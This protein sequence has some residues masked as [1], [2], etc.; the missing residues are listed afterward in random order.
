MARRIE[1]FG[2][3]QQH[4]ENLYHKK[5]HEINS[6][7]KMMNAK[8][9]D[10]DNVDERVKSRYTREEYKQFF[11]DRKRSERSIYVIK[12]HNVRNG[13]VIE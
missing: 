8:Y 13:F 2:V 4:L 5:I 10:W 12:L 1:V 6:A 11:I 9:N 7:L 3:Q